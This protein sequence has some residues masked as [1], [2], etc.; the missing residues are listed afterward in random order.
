MYAK[1]GDGRLA[2]LAGQIKFTPEKLGQIRTLVESGKNR[3]DVAELLG[4]TVNS[5]HVT[6]SRLGISLRRGGQHLNDGTATSASDG[7]Q[8]TKI[9]EVEQDSQSR[10]V[11]PAAT[12]GRRS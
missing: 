1:R 10:P 6:C 7:V 3:Q 8:Q 12:T 5:L 11:N 2:R 4:V 9:A